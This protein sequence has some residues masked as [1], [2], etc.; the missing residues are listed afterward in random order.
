MNIIQLI[1]AIIMVE[2]GGHWD[3]VG[4]NGEIGLMQMQKCVIED[5]NEHYGTNY[6]WPRD[7]YDGTKSQNIFFL[8]TSYWGRKNFGRKPTMEE[9][10]RIWN[11]GPTMAGTD[12]YWN[13]IYEHTNNRLRPE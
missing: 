5:V 8:Y 6:A 11:G 13:K 3:A 1:A 2:S 7:A 10:A 4:A 12:E 9:R